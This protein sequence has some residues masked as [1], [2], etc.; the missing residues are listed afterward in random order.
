MNVRDIPRAGDEFASVALIDAATA[1]LAKHKRDVPADFVAK[2]F[3]LAVPEDLQR[4]TP[5]E[6]AVIT[7][8]AWSF[9]AQRQAGTAKVRFEPVEASH[10]VAVL[11]I[12][13]DDM[14]FLVDSVIGEINHRG[15]DI[16]LFV[17]PVFIVERD[18]AGMLI[19]FKAART[20]GGQRESFICIHIDGLDDAAQRAEVVQTLESILADVRVC[21]QDWQPTL[22]RA[23]AVIADLR[24]N[25]PPLP[26]EEIAEAIQ[27][28]EWIVDDN[29][30][31]L[32]PRE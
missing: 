21:V 30:T 31:L 1:L 11:E 24:A 32:V 19:N 22:V 3:G 29:F 14:P 9:L 28:L 7:E 27:F 13:N 12:V 16:R 2:L 18:D 10:G 8:R 6:L 25:P 15:L 17:H 26:V 4:Y 23:R 20:V 5:D